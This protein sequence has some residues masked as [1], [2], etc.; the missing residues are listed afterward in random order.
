VYARA[1]GSVASVKL[2]LSED[3]AVN[4]SGN[5]YMGAYGN[6]QQNSP[7]AKTKKTTIFV[8]LHIIDVIDFWAPR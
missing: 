4:A 5:I 8:A 7:S 3:A 2:N 6:S 1:T